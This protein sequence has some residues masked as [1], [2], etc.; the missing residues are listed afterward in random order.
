MTPS[1]FRISNVGI[2]LLLCQLAFFHFENISVCRAGYTHVQLSL[3]SEWIFYD[4]RELSEDGRAGGY[5]RISN[6]VA[7][8][9]VPIVWGQD[10]V[11][12]VLPMEGAYVQASVL[13]FDT[14]GRPIGVVR[15]GLP[16]F[17]LP[18]FWTPSG[19][20]SAAHFGRGGG[21]TAAN[22]T[23]LVGETVDP[24]MTD[25]V[26]RVTI[27]NFDGTN[28]HVVTGL[29]DVIGRCW[30][31]NTSGVYVGVA[32]TRI[33]PFLR[34]AFVGINGTADFATYPGYTIVNDFDINDSDWM[35]GI[36]GAAPFR[37]YIAKAFG[38][39]IHDLGLL[40]GYEGTLPEAINNA[41]EIVG[42]ALQGGTPMRALYWSPGAVSPTDLNL[43][44]DLPNDTL[45]EAMDINNAGQILARGFNGYYIFTPVPEPTLA[46]VSC[47]VGLT[48]LPRSRRG[49][50]I[51]SR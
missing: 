4:A 44:V 17:V 16:E 1:P 25:Y 42:G 23:M 15:P 31:V 20:V 11:D 41:G 32:D 24:T 14:T 30:S 2:S 5:I 37:G 38:S 22:A 34:R 33:G 49:A 35:V 40:A 21:L 39:E 26:G 13:G 3:P 28:P 6:D 50:T 48:A 18:S 7:P 12:H 9:D 29:G 45:V 36:H 51:T 46:A 47:A 27:W 10:G 8:I 19:N 43:L